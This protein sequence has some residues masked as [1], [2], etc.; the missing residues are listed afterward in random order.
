MDDDLSAGN[1]LIDRLYL[2][3]IASL[4]LLCVDLSAFL[5]ECILFEY[6]L[7]QKFISS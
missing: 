7:T 4:Y 6:T 1:N 3:G 2:S 5:D